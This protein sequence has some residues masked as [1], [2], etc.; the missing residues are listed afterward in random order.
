M[1][2]VVSCPTCFR[3]YRVRESEDEEQ[4]ECTECGTIL[5]V[6]PPAVPERETNEIDDSTDPYDDGHSDIDS[7]WS[8]EGPRPGTQ[9]SR[10]NTRVDD[11]AVL[12]GIVLMITGCLGMLSPMANGGLLLAIMIADPNANVQAD[13]QIIGIVFALA[14]ILVGAVI[15]GLIFFAGNSMRKCGSYG[16]AMTGAVIAVC[17][18][19]LGCPC[20]PLGLSGIPMAC[21]NM[22]VG[23]WALVGP[24]QYRGQIGIPIAH[25]VCGSR[26]AGDEADTASIPGG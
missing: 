25:G 9:I 24:V 23:I 14:Q 6:P 10:H 26:L 18:F 11:R 12:P 20:T 4:I 5:D 19:M 13:G 15:G 8:A 22:P 21:L 3:E 1:A 16:L 7:K 17:T 2:I